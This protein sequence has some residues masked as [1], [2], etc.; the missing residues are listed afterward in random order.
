[1][2]ARIFG[3]ISAGTLAGIPLG[4]FVSGYVVT[5]LGLQMTLFVMGALYLVT[6]LSLLVNPAITKGMKKPLLLSSTQDS[7]I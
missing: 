7:G 4:T 3:T 5:L 2:R 6:T 1:M